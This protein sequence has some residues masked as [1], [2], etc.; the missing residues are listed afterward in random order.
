HDSAA[1]QLRTPN[2]EPGTGN[3]ERG[4]PNPNPAPSTQNLEP[5]KQVQSAPSARIEKPASEQDLERLETPMRE[6][7]EPRALGAAADSAKAAP[8]AAPSS[9]PLPSAASEPMDRF[10]ESVATTAQRSA[11]AST[12]VAAPESVSSSNPLV[13][14]RIVTGSSIER[15]TDGGKTWAGTTSPATTLVAIRAVDA[16]RAVATNSENTQFYTTN[17]GLSWTRVQEKSAAPF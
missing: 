4:T 8:S 9:A 17:R 15:S 10:A 3:P 12:I 14:W 1:Q 7:A 11:L 16:D 13:R 2:L 6:R 5:Q